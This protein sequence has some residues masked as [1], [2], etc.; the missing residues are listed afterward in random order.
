M[1]ILAAAHGRAAKA[2]VALRRALFTV[3][4]IGSPLLIGTA[5]Y[6]AMHSALFTIRIVEIT[7]ETE[8]SPVDGETIRELAA[9]PVGQASLF[10]VDLARIESRILSNPWI[11]SV[12]IEKRFPQTL[13]I[14]VSYRQPIAILQNGS[15]LVYVDGEGRPFERMNALFQANLPLIQGIREKSQTFS[16][17]LNLVK[18]WSSSAMGALA[19]LSSIQYDSEWGFR[20]WI[21]YRLSGTGE[22]VRTQI[23][24][25]QSIE[26]HDQLTRIAQVVRYLSANHISASLLH[27]DIGKKIVVKTGRRS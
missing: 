22:T 8:A 15:A 19:E 6:G 9:V 26:S 16:P 3:L 2:S 1:A 24:F 17:A 25:G 11:A 18:S 27:A 7:G 21:T 23:V 10:G 4:C 14:S 12:R 20:A 5:I 13:S